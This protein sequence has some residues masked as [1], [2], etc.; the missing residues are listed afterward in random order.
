MAEQEATRD[1]MREGSLPVVAAC[2]TDQ[3]L[4]RHENQDAYDAERTT[5]YTR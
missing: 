3:G 5:V 2:R 4:V 1:R